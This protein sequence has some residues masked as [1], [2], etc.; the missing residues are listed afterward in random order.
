MDR[1]HLKDLILNIM[2][3]ADGTLQEADSDVRYGELLGYAEVLT[4]IKEAIE[5]DD[6][7]YYN[8]D[9]DVE[10]KYII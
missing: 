5:P 4:I 6:W 8:L 3:E 2:H 9:F 7:E 10:K 1:E